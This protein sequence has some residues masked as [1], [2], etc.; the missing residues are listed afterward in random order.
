[1]ANNHSIVERFRFEGT[2]KYNLVQPPAVGKDTFH[3]VRLL[4][5]PS[6]LTL[7]QPQLRVAACASASPP[8]W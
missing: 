8:S 6:S 3:Q 1:M 4:K 2:L 7:R 5:T